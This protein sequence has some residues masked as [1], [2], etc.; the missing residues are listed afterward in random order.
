MSLL[1]ANT[2]ISK[3][4]S[5]WF[6]IP[7]ANVKDFD[8]DQK[9]EYIVKVMPTLGTPNALRH[10]KNGLKRAKLEKLRF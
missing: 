4:L 3:L 9:Y 10:L 5:A 8:N 1:K 7:K 2:A 6:Q